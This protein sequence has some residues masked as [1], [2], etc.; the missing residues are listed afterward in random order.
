MQHASHPQIVKRLKQAHGQISA[1]L[2]MFEEGRSC[3]ELAQQIQAVESVVHTAK[4]ALIQD[5]M[6]HCLGGAAA[7][8]E[9]GAGKALRE[10]KALSKY[11]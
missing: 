2:K 10:F 5:H 3:L 11:L 4:R 7:R 1:I 9:I 6:E 8:D